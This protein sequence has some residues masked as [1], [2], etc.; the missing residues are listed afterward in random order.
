M[1]IL[2]PF[3]VHK[4]FIHVYKASDG[5]NISIAFN[6]YK[7]FPYVHCAVSAYVSPLYHQGPPHWSQI[8]GFA[9]GNC[10]GTGT[11]P[12]VCKLFEPWVFFRTEAAESIPDKSSFL[13]A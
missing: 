1:L 13:E 5:Y 10:I 9:N 12:Q 7:P 3:F 4:V 2:F 6:M 8:G 11:E